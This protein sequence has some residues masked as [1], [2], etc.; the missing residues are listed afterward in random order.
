VLLPA[1][2]ARLPLLTFEHARYVPST[3]TGPAYYLRCMIARTLLEDR[4]P[5]GAVPIVYLP[6]VGKAEL[7]AVEECP[8]ALQPLAELQYRGV[9]W[10]HRN[11]RDWT[12]AGFL[13]VG[14]TPP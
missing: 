8:R 3:R 4:L 2:R 12:V 11:G 10:T 7:R 1:L 13:V 9:L 14:R 5:D 6:G